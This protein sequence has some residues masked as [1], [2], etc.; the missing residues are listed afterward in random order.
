M[1]DE[2]LAQDPEILKII[3]QINDSVIIKAFSECMGIEKES[4]V[5]LLL[6]STSER[7]G[8]VTRDEEKLN[9]DEVIA[10]ILP[11]ICNQRTKYINISKKV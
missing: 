8:Q 2:C 9:L 3:N 1:I 6:G 10:L 11:L 7:S 5:A 4:E